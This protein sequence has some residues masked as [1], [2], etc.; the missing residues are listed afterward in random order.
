[1]ADL[2]LISSIAGRRVDAG[3][4]VYN[5]TK[6]GV[7]AFA[8]SLRQEVTQRYVRVSVVE[9][10]VVATELTSHLAPELRA[11]A[12]ERWRDVTILEADDVADAIE[13]IVTRPRHVAV[14]ELMVRPSE[15]VF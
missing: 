8:E 12:A 2:V 9:P 11:R 10:G 7:G 13:Y 14:N 5:L 3:S 15:S 6:H 4:A 1:V